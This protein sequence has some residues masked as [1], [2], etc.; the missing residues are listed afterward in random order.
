MPSSMISK[1]V[2]YEH[3]FFEIV[4]FSY[5]IILIVLFL[6]YM[7]LKYQQFPP[8]SLNDLLYYC[9]KCVLNM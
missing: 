9:W 6:Y 8:A 3:C 7:T 4:L 2:N 1:Y 5:H